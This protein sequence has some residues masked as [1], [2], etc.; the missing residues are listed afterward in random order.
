MC[1]TAGRRLL[2]RDI[3]V[4]RR[5][6]GARGRKAAFPAVL[7]GRVPAPDLGPGLAVEGR[8]KGSAT[9]I[10]VDPRLADIDAGGNA[11]LDEIVVEV[12]RF[13]AGRADD[14]L[15]VENEGRGAELEF[16]VGLLGA[17]RPAS[18]RQRLAPVR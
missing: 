11:R 18:R 3:A 1:R 16:H 6:V 15:A 17:V 2:R 10:G 8:E 12:V 14:H 5:A 4:E 7:F 13:E 9:Q